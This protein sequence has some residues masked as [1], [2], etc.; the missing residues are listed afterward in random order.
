M[1][2]SYSKLKAKKILQFKV[3]FSLLASP[4]Q[5]LANIMQMCLSM[6]TQ[7]IARVFETIDIWLVY[8]ILG[9]ISLKQFQ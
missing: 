6:R 1:I 2:I 5:N 3:S 7:N 4:K 8:N 9:D